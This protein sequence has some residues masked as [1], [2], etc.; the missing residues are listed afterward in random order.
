MEILPFIILV[1]LK[2]TYIIIKHL[3]HKCKNILVIYLF[4][5][6]NFKAYMVEVAEI[7]VLD[8]AKGTL[9]YIFFRFLDIVFLIFLILL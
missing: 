1:S 6:K 4:S 8:C 9:K 5:M 2:L 7:L 3:A